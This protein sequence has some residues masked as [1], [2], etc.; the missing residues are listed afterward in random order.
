MFPFGIVVSPTWMGMTHSEL[1]ASRSTGGGVTHPGREP[2]SA[3]V[4]PSAGQGPSRLRTAAFPLQVRWI[5]PDWCRLL[6]NRGQAGPGRA[7]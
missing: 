4:S 1:E 5:E 3:A 6:S 7:A 2:P